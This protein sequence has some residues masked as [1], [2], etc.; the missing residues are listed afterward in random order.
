MDIKLL[1][2]WEKNYSRGEE[3]GGR[4]NKLNARKVLHYESRSLSRTIFGQR[5]YCP[6]ERWWQ[7]TSDQFKETEQFCSLP[8]FQNGGFVLV[9]ELPS[10]NDWM[11]KVDLKDAYFS[12]PIHWNSQRN[13]RR[14]IT[15]F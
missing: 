1:Y 8:S 15:K 13:R 2:Q 9:R 7:Q 6:Q 3:T 4:R 14:P 10:A 11:C 5:F 12:I